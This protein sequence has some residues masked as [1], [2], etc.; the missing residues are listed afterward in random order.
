MSLFQVFL[1]RSAGIVLV[2]S[3]I[4]AKFVS[5]EWGNGALMCITWSGFWAVG[6][7]VLGFRS[8][9][10]TLTCESNKMAGEMLLGVVQ[11]AFVLFASMGLAHAF[12]EGVNGSGGLWSPRA[13]LATTVLYMLVLGV[14]IATLAQALSRGELVLST[15]VKSGQQKSDKTKN[16]ERPNG[17]KE[18]AV[19]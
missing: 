17:A 4:A 19:E 6:L 2:T 13:L 3:G 10:K 15:S 1:A 14:E 8:L 7:G 5:D 16:E 11:R 18:E 12:A 9:R